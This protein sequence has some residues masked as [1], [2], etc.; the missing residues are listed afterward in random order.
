MPALTGD[1]TSTVGTV[2]TTLAAGSASN[3]NSGT[4]AA[5]RGGAGTI[6]GAL[7]GNGAGV[8][9]QAAMADISDYA[10]GSWTPTLLGSTSGSW[11]LTT[12][13]G[14]YE[15]IGRNVTVRFTIQTSAASA[16]VGNINIGGLPFTSA[17]VAS[18]N[19][20]CFVG[21]LGGWTSAGGYTLPAGIVVPNAAVAS[22]S[23]AGSGIAQRFMPVG[24]IA[25]STFVAG[26]CNYHI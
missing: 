26:F 12:A 1:V 13:V 14:S 4:L 8:V 6:T 16:P 19:G 20:V 25:A 7:R 15:K 24:S 11:T 22:L 18:D 17:N 2:A 23:E 3:L 5:A 21:I 9:T 10:Q